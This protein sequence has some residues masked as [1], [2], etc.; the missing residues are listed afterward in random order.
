MNREFPEILKLANERFVESRIQFHTNAML[1]TEARADALVQASGRAIIYIS[2]DGGNE[3]THE[4]NR[5]SG[6]YAR[7][8]AGAM[9]LLEARRT[10]GGPRIVLYQIDFGLP[11]SAYDHSFLELAERADE[12]IRVSPVTRLKASNDSGA[13]VARF[14]DSPQESN[15][16]SGGGSANGACFW[17][18]NSISVSPSGDVSIC[19]LSH[20]EV[21]VLGNLNH[22]SVLTAKSHEPRS[23]LF[24]V[25]A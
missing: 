13:P 16:A 12:W 6:T 10:S 2:I 4:G 3:A 20:S 9:R 15:R 24:H 17:A 7:A 25:L 23:Q 18:G 5:G 21:G 14:T 1:I 11:L 22:T 19:I 8:L